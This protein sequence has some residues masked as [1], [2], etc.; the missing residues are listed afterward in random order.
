MRG[1]TRG[2]ASVTVSATGTTISL[3]TTEDKES[4]D[5]VTEKVTQVTYKLVVK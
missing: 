4:S 3:A 2:N 5:I 1:K